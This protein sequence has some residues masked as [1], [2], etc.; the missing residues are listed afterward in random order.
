MPMS[1]VASVLIVDDDDLVRAS[2]TAV[3]Q[4]EKV[5]RITAVASA[6]EAFKM[7]DVE[8][9]SVIICD[10]ELPGING[11]VFVGRLRLKKDMTPVLFISGSIAAE[12][13]TQA[14]SR[15]MAGFLQKPFSVQDLLSSVESLV[16]QSATA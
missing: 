14:A 5:A 7:L 13:I 2:L 10:Y 3:F 4:K 1:S 15:L 6:E 11:V 8:P 12:K 16:T 9:F